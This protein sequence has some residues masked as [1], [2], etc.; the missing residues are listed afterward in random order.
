M[1]LPK[2]VLL[3]G[4]TYYVRRPIP[5]DVQTAYPTSKKQIWKSLGTTVRREAEARSHAA[6]AAIEQGF[7]AKRRLLRADS[8]ERAFLASE[9]FDSALRDHAALAGKM[10]T[11]QAY[12][13]R[14]TPDDRGFAEWLLKS[15]QAQRRPA[16]RAEALAG[17]DADLAE[18][19]AEANVTSLVTALDEDGEPVFGNI[20]DRYVPALTAK[21]QELVEAD[22][23]SLEATKA[24]IA[25]SA[26]AA[27]SEVAVPAAEASLTTL[28]ELWKRH[29]SPAASSQADMRTAIKRFEAVNGPLTYRQIT[30]EHARRFKMDLIGDAALKNATRQKLWGMLRALLNVAVDDALLESNPFIRVKLTLADDSERRS[31]LTTEDLEALFAKLRG[32]EEEWWVTRIGLYSGA[33]LAEICQLAKGDFVTVASV[34]AFHIR[35]DAEVGTS[36]KT[37]SSVRKVPVHRQLVADG[38]LEWVQTRKVERLFSLSGAVASKRLARVFDSVGLGDDKVFHSLRHTFKGVARRHMAEEWHDRL[39]GHASKSVGQDYGDYDLRTLKEKIDLIAFGIEA[40]AT[41]TATKKAA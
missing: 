9:A 37:R 24:I 35:A 15:G 26:E 2:Y 4:D 5:L 32:R 36:V 29:R 14:A 23:R 25:S 8:D 40:P 20:P 3:R 39:T 17:I 13:P 33:R 10:M 41:A 19:N 30:D 11:G 12:A 6:L 22:R 1:S 27:A 31:V 34:P 18:L 38:L 21:M 16:T 7:D 28:S